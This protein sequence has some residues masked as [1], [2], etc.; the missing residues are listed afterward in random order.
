ML[1]PPGYAG[2]ARVESVFQGMACHAELEERSMVEPDGIEP[3]T[4]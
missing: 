2:Q 3:T 4:F 1:R